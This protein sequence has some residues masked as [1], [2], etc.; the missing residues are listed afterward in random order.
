MPENKNEKLSHDVG[1]KLK[2]EYCDTV[3]TVEYIGT[4]VDEA[5]SSPLSIDRITEILSDEFIGDL[6]TSVENIRKITQS[7]NTTL[8]K[9]SKL[10][11]TSKV[12]IENLIKQSETLISSL[13]K[14]SDNL[15][16]I[17]SDE[18]LKNDVISSIKS[19]GQMS[20]NINQF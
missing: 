14:L 8:D 7:A 11:D 6:K 13:T 1:E 16:E 17:V 9:A 4:V 2:I 3:H 5:K 15:N 20:D 19:I 10:I 18:T 12:E